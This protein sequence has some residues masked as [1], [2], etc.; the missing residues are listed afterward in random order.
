MGKKNSEH[1]ECYLEHL[2]LSWTAS[3]DNPL[4]NRE[5]FAS[6][7]STNQDTWVWV[8]HTMPWSSSISAYIASSSPI[9][10]TVPGAINSVS[11]MYRMILF[12]T[13]SLI[14]V[15]FVESM[16]MVLK[17][18]HIDWCILWDRG[19]DKTTHCSISR[20]WLSERKI[21]LSLITA[22]IFSSYEW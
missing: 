1:F 16:L 17:S 8:L 4:S 7:C 18:C 20:R 21:C 19:C 5:T 14:Q 2:L 6:R 15:L 12:K 13:S 10:K 11:L 22:A 3:H 9:I